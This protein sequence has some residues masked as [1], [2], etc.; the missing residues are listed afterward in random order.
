M[1]AVISSNC[2]HA[3]GNN[4]LLSNGAKECAIVVNLF[5][6]LDQEDQ[7]ALLEVL[8]SYFCHP[9]SSIDSDD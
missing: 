5:I 9:K 3:A 7:G 6:S 8:D 4:T 2:C 1:E